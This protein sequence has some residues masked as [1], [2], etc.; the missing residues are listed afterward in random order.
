MST[1]AYIPTAQEVK[2]LRDR[3]GAGMMD[4]KKALVESGGDVDQAIEILRK[5]AGKRIEDRG[6]RTASE[7]TV[8][9]YIHPNAKVGVLVE[10]D[11]ETDFVARNDDFVAFAKDI[12]L[13]IA[14]A[15]PLFVIEE[16]VDPALR[17]KEAQAFEEQASDKP[18]NIRPRIVEGQLKK[19]LGEI[20]LLNQV[21]VNEDK[22]EGKTIK[23][24]QD[25]IAAKTG[26]NVRIRRFARFA[27]GQ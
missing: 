7:G 20:V 19:W 1:E 22:Y 26:E 21:H 25:E 3:T 4:S 11:C 14:A 2:A 6:E 5:K 17:E 10:V 18:E 24:L 23:Q 16:D 8:Q 13:H 15:N 27:I 12:A 9:T